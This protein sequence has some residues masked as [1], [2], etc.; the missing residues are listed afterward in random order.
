LLAH[1]RMPPKRPAELN[2]ILTC[3]NKSLSCDLNSFPECT[4]ILMIDDTNGQYN[5]GFHDRCRHS[6]LRPCRY[7]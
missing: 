1:S 7:W 2:L 5:A 4:Q 6:A 3:W